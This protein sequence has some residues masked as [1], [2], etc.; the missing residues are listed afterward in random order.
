VSF[1]AETNDYVHYQLGIKYKNEQK[2]DQAVEEFRKVLGAYPDNYNAYMHLAEINLIQGNSR[3]SIFY[4]KK[5]LA[6][7]PG[8]GKAQKL[9]AS[10]Y[11][12]E[13][14]YS[15]AIK[16]LQDYSL[17]CDPAERDS[18]QGLVDNLITALQSGR[19]QPVIKTQDD[20]SAGK[21]DVE[22]KVGPVVDAG[23][24]KDRPGPRS[25]VQS[26]SS[27]TGEGA[28]RKER[29]EVEFTEGVEAYSL[30]IKSGK[31]DDFDDALE[32]FRKTLIIK[33]DH[34]GASYYAGL[35]CRKQGQTKLAEYNFKRAVGYPILGMN[36]YFYL[37]KIYGE[38]GRYQDAISNLNIYIAQT[39]YVQGKREAQ[40]LIDRYTA[41][42]EIPKKE[43]ASI[44]IASV[45]KEEME[46]EIV[47]IPPETNYVPLEVRIDSL[48]YM[49]IVDTL[50]DPGQEMLAGVKLFKQNKFDEAIEAFKKVL[51]KYP[52]GDVSIRCLYDIGVCLLKI[53]NYP[54]AE[55]KFQQ[56][57]NQHRSHALVP[58]CLFWIAYSYSERREPAR[59]EKMYR[60]YIQKYRDHAW[61]GRA[62]EKLGDVYND[63]LQ[64]KKAIDAFQNAAK[65]ARSK[66]DQIHALY[67]MGEG[68]VKVGNSNRAVEIYGKVIETGEKEGLF[69]RVPDAYY[70]TAD[71][72]YKQKDYTNALRY[73]KDVT[74]RYPDYQD[75]PWGLFQIASIYKNTKQYEL[76]IQSF[77]N[78]IGKY[79]GDYWA[80]QAKWKMEDTVWEYQ[81]KEVL[82]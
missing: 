38:E 47:K 74:R 70:S 59:A 30:G 2:Y 13:G 81:Y 44:D 11:E 61:T 69:E 65:N 50:T 31:K 73:Y 32:H 67:K 54:G 35:V 79:P 19:T 10:V 8:W 58:Q 37:G 34:A 66:K 17:S 40:N 7:N 55:G 9:L 45:G 33:P 46:R 12:K 16:E 29:A 72:Y 75:T 80:L 52:A 71:I 57:I 5:S 24:K 56:I 51:Q 68:Y 64:D 49:S 21:E 28:G 48:L 76:S 62:Y 63:M 41:A 3:L 26:A 42:L 1:A 22:K 6:F 20:S 25:A 36:A 43:T 23:K 82:K 18:I 77:K 39:D 15:N 78:L 27:R 4:L 60:E 14:Q 53:R